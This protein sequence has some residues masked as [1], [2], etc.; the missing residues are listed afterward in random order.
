M[1]TCVYKAE[2]I[3]VSKGF[4][5]SYCSCTFPPP[6]RSCEI[7]SH[8]RSGCEWE[9]LLWYPYFRILSINVC[10]LTKSSVSSHFS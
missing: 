5:F 10:F 3:A 2:F 9:Y 8:F 4:L 7:E 6:H 1:N